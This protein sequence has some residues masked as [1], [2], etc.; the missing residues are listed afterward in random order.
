M[1][2]WFTRH[3]Q[4]LVGSLG[5]LAQAPI[6]NSLT[7]LVIGIALALPASL[8]VLVDN[9]L[10]V[11]SGWAS[12]IDVAVYLKH[13]TTADEAK[14][15]ADRI[16]Q[17]RD[18]ANVEFVDADSALASFREQSGFG[19]ALDALE[20]NP[21]PH[22]LVIRPGADFATAPHAASIAD[23]IGKLPEVEYVQLDTEWVSRLHAILETVRRAVLM[24]GAL[25]GIGVM[26]IV[27]NTIRLDIENRRQEIEVT[28]LVGGSDGFVRRPFLYSGFWYGLGGG[29]VAWLIVV[30][31][32]LLL[33]GPVGRIAGL[34]GSSYSLAGLDAE[35]SVALLAAGIAL[36]WA[37]SYF[38]ATR[39][40]R[41]IEPA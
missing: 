38:A 34:Y 29:L 10:T 32:V 8:H 18:V 40:L 1:T 20:E 41:A 13:G 36:G 33:S 37:G 35:A 24:A 7:V 5:R 27:G 22:L 26:V 23:D 2:S 28:K 4:T 15:V 14:R 12:E 39:H 30:L 31:V 6:A 3:L 21:L 17:R 11:S 25:L 9:A 16:G 19:P